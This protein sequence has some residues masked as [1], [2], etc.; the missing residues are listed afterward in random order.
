MPDFKGERVCS[1]DEKGRLVIPAKL[2]EALQGGVVITRWWECAVIFP[3]EQWDRFTASFDSFSVLDEDAD[4]LKRHFIAGAA[5]CVPDRMGRI[6]L[7][8]HLIR[9]FGLEKDVVVAGM[10]DR[11]EIWNKDVWDAKHSPENNAAL[12]AK[13]RLLLGKGGTGA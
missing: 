8:P 12:R 9:A 1:V 3:P 13:A 10:I 7:P 6:T 5:D 4:E 2:R 11:L